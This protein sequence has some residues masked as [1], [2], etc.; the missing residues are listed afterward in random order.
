M[1]RLRRFRCPCLVPWV[2]R[3]R[4]SQSRSIDPMA[5]FAGCACYPVRMET[6]SAALRTHLARLGA[7]KA[8]D[9]HVSAAEWLALPL[10]ERLRRLV[11]FCDEPGLG[12]FVQA[13]DPADEI[14]DEEG[15]TWMRVNERLR[16][17]R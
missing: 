12:R 10:A 2:A 14:P 17:A 6:E 4:R 8:A 7:T 1:R 16:R 5:Q 15:A 9:Q 3:R 13:D 11:A